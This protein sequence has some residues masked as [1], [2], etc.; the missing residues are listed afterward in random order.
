MSY[1]AARP[2]TKARLWMGLS[3]GATLLCCT[4][5][6]VVGIVYSAL[7]I[8]AENRGDHYDAAEKVGKAKGWTIA[9]ICIGAVITPLYIWVSVKNNTYDSY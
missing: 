2:A 4:I 3:I 9:A 5:F 6:G 8:S 1:E 7:A